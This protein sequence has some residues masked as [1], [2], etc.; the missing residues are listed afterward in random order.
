MNG[1]R[2]SHNNLDKKGNQNGDEEPAGS[3]IQEEDSFFGNLFLDSQGNEEN[4]II[5]KE[6]EIVCLYFGAKSCPPTRIFTPILREYYDEVN[7]LGKVFE[8]I[9]VS[10]DKDKEDFEQYIEMMPW[11]SIPYDDPRILEFKKNYKIKGIPSLVC[12]SDTGVVITVNGR[13]DVVQKGEDAFEEWKAAR[14]IIRE[15]EM[16]IEIEEAENQPIQEEE[17]GEDD[18]N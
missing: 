13:N 3:E 16:E 6:V 10:R 12:L 8:I 4:A 17:I 11:Y 7:M 2:P 5:L 15:K 18:K 14:E 1:R 9:Y